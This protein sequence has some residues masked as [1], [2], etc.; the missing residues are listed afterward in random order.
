[1]CAAMEL[2]AFLITVACVSQM[3]ERLFWSITRLTPSTPYPSLFH[4]HISIISCAVW[5]ISALLIL[6]L[7]IPF[8]SERSQWRVWGHKEKECWIKWALFSDVPTGSSVLL[9]AVFHPDKDTDVHRSVSRSFQ[10][11][12]L[13]HF[14]FSLWNWC[15]TLLSHYS[16]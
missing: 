15:K 16:V 1:M 6:F 10:C 5:G 12:Q 4:F 14:S 13:T 8:P 9:W 7:S 3:N 2:E 11:K